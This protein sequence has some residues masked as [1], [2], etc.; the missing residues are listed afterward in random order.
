MTYKTQGLRQRGWGD[1]LRLRDWTEK[2]E[3]RGGDRGR[4]RERE[5]VLYSSFLS[6]HNH[7]SLIR[8]I[9]YVPVDLV[10]RT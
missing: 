1:R 6:A 3:E 9:N 8:I 7:Y 5:R 10:S 4:E 2:E